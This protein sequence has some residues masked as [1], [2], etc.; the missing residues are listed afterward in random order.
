MVGNTFPK[1]TDMDNC[2]NI[3]CGMIW[4]KNISATTDIPKF[5][6]NLNPVAHIHQCEN[7]WKR[8]A[9]EMKE[10][11]PICFQYIR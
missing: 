4:R 10:C 5:K 3:F 2:N 9:I 8:L 7:E 6:P 11:G 1:I